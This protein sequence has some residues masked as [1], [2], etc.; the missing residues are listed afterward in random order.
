MSCQTVSTMSFFGVARRA[1][2]RWHATRDDNLVRMGYASGSR[3]H[4][5]DFGVPFNPSPRFVGKADCRLVLF[6]VPG[7]GQPLLDIDEFP[8]LE[9]VTDQIEWRDMVPL[10]DLPN[11]IARF[12]INLAPLETG[13]IFCEAKSELKYFEASLADVAQSPRRRDQWPG[14]YG[15][16]RPAC[17]PPLRT[18]GM[19]HYRFWWI[20]LKPGRAWRALATW[21]YSPDLVQTV[22]RSVF[23]RCFE[24]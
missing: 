3:T 22:S 11:E 19:I 16:M 2:R 12:D 15:M 4:Q 6:R 9:P 5:R 18:I 20:S 24:S 1:A 14:P 7:T 10:K 23:N 17:S 8:C 21:M 13:N